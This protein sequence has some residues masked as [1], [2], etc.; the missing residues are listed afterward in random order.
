MKY[1]LTLFICLASILY[2]VAQPY[3]LNLCVETE[4]NEPVARVLIS[5]NDSTDASGCLSVSNF[6]NITIAPEKNIN[7]TN[8]VTTFDLITIAYHV[9]GITLLDS[10][11]KL[12]AAD[13]SNDGT[14]STFDIVTITNAILLNTDSFPN[15]SS[16]RFVDKSYVFPN[17][18]NPFNPGF[19]EEIIVTPPIPDTV[20]AEFVGIKIGDVNNS[21]N[22]QNF[23]ASSV[24]QRSG[25]SLQFML[26]NQ[27]LE[28]GQSYTATFTAANW[29]EI[30]GF[31]QTISFQPEYLRF[32]ALEH[33]VLPDFGLNNIG[34]NFAEEGFITMNWFTVTPFDMEEDA[35]LFKLTFEVLKDCKVSDVLNITADKIPVESYNANLDIMGIEL[36]FSTLTANSSFLLSKNIKIY[37]N[38][39]ADELT[40]EYPFTLQDDLTI[41]IFP[42]KELK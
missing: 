3:H 20:N 17:L 25:S 23:N 6:S 36:L 8:G 41:T 42:P 1:T 7:L 24:D 10:P 5:P 30:L 29:K 27:Q 2:S 37:P 11:Y 26:E 38:P 15:N 28:V 35:H 39:V 32:K 14:I 40:L 9:L 13:A 12:I 21:G 18:S 19:P 31:Q 16:W 4:T 33:G 34:L 22:P